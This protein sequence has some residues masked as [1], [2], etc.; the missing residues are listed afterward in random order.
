LGARIRA[1]AGAIALVVGPLSAGAFLAL[2]PGGDHAS[3]LVA[4]VRLLVPESLA[5][6]IRLSPRT[7]PAAR[8][9]E[10]RLGSAWLT[11]D[12]ALPHARVAVP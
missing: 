3:L 9:G 4:L 11:P 7:L 6:D 10:A 8:L 5:V 2:R 12:A 1:P